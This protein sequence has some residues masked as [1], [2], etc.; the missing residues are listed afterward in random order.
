MIEPISA[1]CMTSTRG[2]TVIWS[3]EIT[4]FSG[5]H[6]FL[7]LLKCCS[8]VSL[9]FLCHRTELVA[10]CTA[11]PWNLLPHRHLNLSSLSAFGDWLVRAVL[12]LRLLNQMVIACEM[13]G[14]GI[15]TCIIH[16][17]ARFSYKLQV[18]W[19]WFFRWMTW[20]VT[21]PYI[22]KKIMPATMEAP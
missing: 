20:I 18:L 5:Y 9:F 11:L 4:K 15:Y 2:W 10:Y 16:R 7:F 13:L 14:T 19:S 1:Q 17:F 6:S 3:G 21:A 12:G 8:L 22:P